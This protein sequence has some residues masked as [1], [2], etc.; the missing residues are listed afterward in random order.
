MDAV[1]KLTGWVRLRLTSA[2][3]AARLRE[4]SGQYRLEKVAFPDDLTAEFDISAPDARSLWVPDGERLE[5][6]GGGG[7]PRLLAGLGRWKILT[8]AVLILGVLTVFLPTRVWFVEV[9]GSG[10][11]PAALILERAE[12]CGVYF[13]ASRRELRS[14]QVKNHL[15]WA[16]PELK[17]AGVNT[18]GCV[19]VITVALRQEGEEPLSGQPGDIVAASDGVVSEIV[20]QSG[21]VLAVHGQAVRAGDVLISGTSDLGTVVLAERAAG[22]VYGLTRRDLTAVLPAEIRSKQENGRVLRKFSL[23]IGKKYVNFS[24][25]SGILHGT[26]VKMRTVNYL[27]LPGG[28]QLP[29]ALVTETYRLCQTEPVSREM[30][31]ELL[32]D[33]VRRYA[34]EAMTAGTILREEVSVQGDRL[35]AVLHCREL[36]GVF[37]PGIETEGDTNERENRERGA[38]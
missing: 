35:R 16:I 26:C 24:N 6:I 31:T 12:E 25:D 19:A 28:F 33:E 5:R 18:E 1:W 29:V 17:W 13:G 22:E 7:I 21:T 27:T 4:F 20:N 34:R 30:D 32:L 8:A 9:R 38:G 37:R 14:E 3:P 15:L 2:D 36:I 23:R 11:V 10:G